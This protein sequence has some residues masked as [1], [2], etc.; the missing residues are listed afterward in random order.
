M[1]GGWDTG[2]LPRVHPTV[3][4]MLA[5]AVARAAGAAALVCEERQLSYAE[6]LRCVAGFAR[7]LRQMG[8]GGSRVA[9]VCGNSLDMPVATFAVNASG[10]QALR[11]R[12]DD[13]I[14]A[15]MMP[16][17]HVEGRGSHQLHPK[18]KL[19]KVDWIPTEEEV[20]PH[21]TVSR[22]PGS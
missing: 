2:I 10:A 22:P 9:L 14:I 8:A 3:V 15:C 17:F 16:L 11:S 19:I 6:Y 21:T 4:H 18:G 1:S 12:A 7:E 5:D 13:E 20:A